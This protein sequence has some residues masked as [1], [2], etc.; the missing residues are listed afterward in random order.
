[1]TESYFYERLLSLPEIKVDRVES[2]PKRIDI[3]C[4]SESG[5]A[6]CPVCQKPT[7]ITNQ[8]YRRSW[9]LVRAICLPAK[10]FRG[11]RVFLPSGPAS[12][13]AAQQ[14]NQR[15]GRAER[16]CVEPNLAS[17]FRALSAKRYTHINF[18]LRS[19]EAFCDI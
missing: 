3:Y 2:H 18:Y 17:P 15:D 8:S 19:S 7:S 5:S 1:M 11:I 16:P 12:Q 6:I 4:H 10:G 9:L 13:P 14:A